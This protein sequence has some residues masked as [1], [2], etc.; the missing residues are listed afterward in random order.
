MPPTI[1]LCCSTNRRARCCRSAVTTAGHKGFALALLV[2]ALTAG[3][4]GLGRADPKEG[5][6]ATVFVQ[7]IDP[8]AFGGADAMRRQMDHIVAACH[9]SA[10]RDPANPVRMPGERAQ[11]LAREQRA[12]GVALDA[13]ILPLIAPWAQRLGVTMPSPMR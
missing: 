10:P 11:K 13:S 4:A 12:H 1:L 5:W 9:A 8:S 7:V 3:L 2:E 6:G